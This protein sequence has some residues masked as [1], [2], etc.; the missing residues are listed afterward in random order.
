MTSA[1]PTEFAHGSQRI[2][3]WAQGW[4]ARADFALGAWDDALKT[5]GTAVP[6]QGDWIE[7]A[8]PWPHWTASK[9]TPLRGNWDAAAS[10][11]ERGTAASDSYPVM[12]LP[13]CLAQAQ[14]AETKADYDGVIRALIPVLGLQR[15]SGIDEP[16]F[17]PWQDHYA[18]A[19]VMTGQVAEADAFLVPHEQLANERNHRSTQARL[20]AVRGRIQAANGDL[21]AAR[22]SF[23][24]GLAQLDGLPL[25]YALGTSSASSPMASRSVVLA[26]VERRRP[27]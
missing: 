12:L 20:A 24:G 19:L 21:D 26:S 7:L 13:Y 8:R 5:V 22:T 4:L 25:P 17:W 6:M 16:G 1:V 23:V 3:L 10:H 14:V 18:N 2:S 27:Y 15:H 9:S 11:L